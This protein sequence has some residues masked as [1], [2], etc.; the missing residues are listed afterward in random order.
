MNKL[1]AILFSLITAGFAQHLGLGII[2]G[3]PTGF[4][5]KVI[6][7][8]NSAVAANI[9]WSITENYHLHITTDY[10]FLFPSVIRWQD[11]MTG[12]QKEIKGLIPF[13]GVGGRLRIKE[14]EQNET[15]LHIGM[16]LGGGIEYTIVRFGIF[17]EIYPVVNI[18]PATDFDLEGGLGIRFYFK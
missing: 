4:T 18:F 1:G 7:T 8:K 11:E 17:L 10:Q 9:G 5:G 16:R 3:S 12:E 13:L 14:T 6:F 2:L 15:E